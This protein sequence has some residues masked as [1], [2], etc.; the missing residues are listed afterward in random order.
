MSDSSYRFPFY[1]APPGSLVYRFDRG[2]YGW[3]FNVV[4]GK[5]GRVKTVERYGIE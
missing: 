4:P 5:D 2:R 3:Q 1:P